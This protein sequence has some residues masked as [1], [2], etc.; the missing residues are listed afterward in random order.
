MEPGGEA[1]GCIK[2]KMLHK[3][4]QNIIYIANYTCIF[5]YE[6]KQWAFQ[7]TNTWGV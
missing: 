1:N 4:P 7:K 2:T 3:R 6:L 5:L